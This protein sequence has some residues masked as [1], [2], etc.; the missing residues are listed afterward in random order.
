M[1]K[2]SE[3]EVLDRELDVRGATNIAISSRTVDHEK[4]ARGW[5]SR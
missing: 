1:S 3:E 2:F 4:R 5:L